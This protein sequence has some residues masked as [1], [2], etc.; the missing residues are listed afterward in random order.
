MF[1]FGDL[2]FVFWLF[3]SSTQLPTFSF[4]IYRF[5]DQISQLKIKWTQSLNMN[6]DLTIQTDQENSA[7]VTNAFNIS[8]PNLNSDNDLGYYI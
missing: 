8:T 3:T 4:R 5:S 1:R 6:N 2:F 7:S